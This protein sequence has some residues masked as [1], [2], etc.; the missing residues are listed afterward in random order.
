MC[1]VANDK[2]SSANSAEAIAAENRATAYTYSIFFMMSMPP[3]VLAGL[4][5]AI[6]REIRKAGDQVGTLT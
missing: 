2:G 1:K 4:T 3:L 6:R 5:V